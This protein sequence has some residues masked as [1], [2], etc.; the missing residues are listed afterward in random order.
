MK[1]DFLQPISGT[2]VI[3]KTEER[4]DWLWKKFNS[5]EKNILLTT[6]FETLS[7]KE[8][9]ALIDS[10]REYIKLDPTSKYEK[11]IG[12][13]GYGN[14]YDLCDDPPVVIKEIRAIPVESSRTMEPM[15][16]RY[17]RLKEV[18]K[19]SDASWLKLPKHYG[20][21]VKNDPTDLDPIKDRE[22][23]GQR[24]GFAAI[25]KVNGKSITEIREYLYEKKSQSKI[26]QEMES[27]LRKVGIDSE[28]D[29]PMTAI[30]QD[31]ER[32][33]KRIVG[34]APYKWFEL[35]SDSSTEGNVMITEKSFEN[36]ELP[37][38]VWLVDL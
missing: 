8:R 1:E 14:V 30:H 2:E 24:H 37:Y 16:D 38:D 21:I 31:I 11:K 4:P 20:L 33:Y 5:G 12:E 13:G 15:M 17:L 6:D 36:K 3:E 22:G 26:D 29:D 10:L 23:E 35:P 34:G 27:W 9:E 32:R 7:D 19:Q 18:L 28:D 25:E